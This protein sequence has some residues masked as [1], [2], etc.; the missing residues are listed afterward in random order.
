MSS[1][2]DTLHDKITFSDTGTKW[3][4]KFGKVT[5]HN[6]SL[7]S[8]SRIFVGSINHLSNDFQQLVVQ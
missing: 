7:K 1:A 8:L 2:Y 3:E 5:Y 6:L 4:N